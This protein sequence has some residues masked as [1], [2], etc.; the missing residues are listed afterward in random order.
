VWLPS[1]APGVYPAPCVSARPGAIASE[2]PPPRQ[3]PLP[4][5][6][7][8]ALD[9]STVRLW[10]GQ[11][12]LATDDGPSDIPTLTVV[13]TDGAVSY[14]T[15]VI[16]APGGGYQ[17]LATGHEGRQIADWFAAHGV[18]A[19]VLR[20]RLASAGI[21]IRHNSQT[22]NE[23]FVGCGQTPQDSACRRSASA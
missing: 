7:R 11:A 22:P 8:V 20:Y 23:R 10:E 1:A 2:T 12:P 3:T 6:T 17:T 18:M 15:A 5:D 9:L 13:G 19:F 4:Y 21:G 14:G 16:V